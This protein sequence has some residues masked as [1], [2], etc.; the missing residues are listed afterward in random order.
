MK[1]LNN[2]TLL[3]ALFIVNWSWSQITIDEKDNLIKD[4]K[5][6]SKLVVDNLD[7]QRVKVDGIAAV[8]GEYLILESDIAKAQEDQKAQGFSGEETS[9][10]FILKQIMENK[11]FAHHAIQDS[12]EIQEEMVN[13]RT[14]QQLQYMVNQ[15]GSLQKILDFYGKDTEEELKKELF[16]INFETVLAQEMQGSVVEEIEVT[17]AEVRQFFDK[18][19]ED[20]KPFF[21]TQV[22]VSQIVIEPEVTEEQTQKTLDFLNKIRQEVLDGARFSSRAVL[23]SDDRRSRREGGRI[24]DVSRDS[25][26]VKEFKDTAFSLEEGEISKPFKTEFGWHILLV[27]KI[28]GQFIDVRHILKFPEITDEAIEKAQKEIQTLRTRIVDGE[29]S[30]EEAAK[31]FSDEEETKESG[32]QL[33][34]DATLDK[35]FELSKMDPDL[36]NKIINLDEGQ[37]SPVYTESNKQQQPFFKILTVTKRLEEHEANFNKDYARISDL[38]LKQKKVREIQKWQKSKM[39]DTYIKI[40]ED[41]KTCDFAKDWLK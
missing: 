33:I 28:R 27:E 1:Y 14:E 13:S 32:G 2:L 35:R 3:S 9:K 40:S 10:C 25:P 17:P 6:E 36:Y 7:N 39:K 11:L 34:N 15:A 31:E 38:A 26:L 22:E 16:D 4:D 5:K 41:Y 21:G 24:S 18:I 8:V 29:I 37:V 20:E 19:P 12:I 30:F 23:Y